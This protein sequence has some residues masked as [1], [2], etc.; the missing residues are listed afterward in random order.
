MSE[1]E[2]LKEN[3]NLGAYVKE[4]GIVQA[5]ADNEHAVDQRGT[6]TWEEDGY[7]V[8]RGNARTAPGCHD[9]CGILM[10]I[11]DGKVVKVEGDEEDPYNQGVCAFAASL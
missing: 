10:Y 1:N 9:N 11:K 6:Y 7:T 5:I 8:V 2:A 4:A 3:S